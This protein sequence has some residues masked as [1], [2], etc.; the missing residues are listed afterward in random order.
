MAVDI[1]RLKKLADRDEATW[2]TSRPT[3]ALVDATEE[4]DEAAQADGLA[5]V[6][7]DP[8]PEPVTA[9]D[10]QLYRVQ[11]GAYPVYENAKR[12]QDLARWRG[13]RDALVTRSNNLYKVQL[14]AYSVYEYALKQLEAAKK[15]G[16]G[17]AFIISRK[18]AVL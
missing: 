14:G 8:K 4:N 13:F 3:D 7:P 18:T 1:P 2:I 12:Q 17:D 9:P 10:E 16:F 11:V 5:P 15:A 6:E